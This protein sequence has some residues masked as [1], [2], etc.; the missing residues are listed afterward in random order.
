MMASPPAWAS[1]G[2]AHDWHK[3]AGRRFVGDCDDGDMQRRFLTSRMD[4]L[5]I[6]VWHK[7]WREKGRGGRGAMMLRLMLH[8]T[9]CKQCKYF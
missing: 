8:V 4:L 6:K 9:I 3:H 7:G 2:S 1:V 5:H